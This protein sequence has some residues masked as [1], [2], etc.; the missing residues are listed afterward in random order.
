MAAGSMTSGS[1]VLLS[2]LLLVVFATPA[3]A[4]GAGNIPSIAQIE[5]SNFRHGDIE[6][7]LKTIA[8]IRGHKWTSM[9]V[10]RVYFGNWLRDYSQ[11]VDVGS[12]K[13]VSAPT[14]R[15]LV[16][17]LSF[18]SFGYATEEF[19]V[20]EER[21]GTY[22]PEE[23]ID[24]PKGYAD[25]KDARQYDSRLRGPVQPI[26]LE[27][28][29]DT[30]MKNYIA[31]ES[32]GWA[33]ST[34]YVKFSLERSIHFGRLYT[35]G[36]GS[37][38]G[39]EADLCEALRCLGQALHCLEDFG[40]HTNYCE[41]ALRELGYRDVFP[42]TGVA[43]EINIRGQHIYPLVTGT[44]GAVDFLHSVLGEATDHFTQTEVEEMDL[45]LKGAEQAQAG[46]GT[47]FGSGGGSDFVSLL[48]QVPGMGGGLASTA[49]SLQESSAEQEYQNTLARSRVETS[50]AGPPGSHLGQSSN[51]VPGMS[52]SFDPIKTSK[53]IYPILEFRDKVV[54]AISATI[55]KIPGLE[56]LVEKISEKL[57]VFVL[58]LLA[59]FIRPIIDAVSKS[60]KDGSSTV[61]EASAKQQFEPWNDAHCTN[62]THSMLSKDHF[63]NKLNG[64]AGRVAT[65]ILQYVTPR[66]LYAWENPGVS[67]GEVMRDILRAFH[68][69]ALRDEQCELHRNMFNT[70][71]KWVDEQPDRHQLN[72]ILSSASVKAGHNHKAS[73]EGGGSNS[74]G[75]DHAHDHGALGGHGKTSGSIWTEIRSRDLGAMEGKDG[76]S[77]SAYSYMSPSSQPNSPGMMHPPAQFGYSNIVRP[78]SSSY[79][80]PTSSPGGPPPGIYQQHRPEHINPPY[81]PQQSQGSFQ[82]PPAGYYPPHGAPPYSPSSA[83]YPPDH[84]Q[85]NYSGPGAPYDQGPGPGGFYPGPQGP[86]PPGWQAG[87]PQQPPYN[88]GGGGGYPGSGYGGGY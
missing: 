85:P 38:K 39:K 23:H 71:R 8:F 26:E 13:G 4:F 31:N 42:H 66:V 88:G 48:S 24:N 41:L 70:V 5:G 34:G 57:T 52:E 12:L 84:Q 82:I 56:A 46:R 78:G 15:I 87:P 6:D 33:T 20:T 73:G 11:A 25:D 77:A 7:M 49:R 30:G 72:Q 43:T 80:R 86:P 1:W 53:R 74:R 75:L 32:G 59:P 81:S 58:S 36:S 64:V 37:S 50:F 10:K 45:A 35:N 16:W 28:D 47:L 67:T 17:V 18:L 69:P 9:M 65:T 2:C 51:Q 76:R 3:A 19:E 21:L 27:V 55:A 60:L 68:H 61:V 54:K 40:A 22:R 29:M 14:I 83:P 44:F 79:D 63:S 62:P